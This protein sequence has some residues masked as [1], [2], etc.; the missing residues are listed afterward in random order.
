MITLDFNKDL[1]EL[2]FFWSVGISVVDID[3]YLY[4]RLQLCYHHQQGPI[5]VTSLFLDQQIENHFSLGL[6]SAHHVGLC[7]VGYLVRG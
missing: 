2:M 5:F 6:L 3:S 4:F 1:E 7:L